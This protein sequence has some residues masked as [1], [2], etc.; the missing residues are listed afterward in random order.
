MRTE[1]LPFNYELSKRFPERRII[2][3]FEGGALFAAE[4]DG[5]FYL[6]ND[7]RTMAEFILP[8][9]DGLLEQMLSVSEFDTDEERKEYLR[10]AS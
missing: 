5:K 8:E 4:R 1:K 6:I 7:Q 10:Q 3:M 2:K 9:D